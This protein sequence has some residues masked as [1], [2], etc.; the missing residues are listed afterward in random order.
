MHRACFRKQLPGGR[1]KRLFVSY[2]QRFYQGGRKG[3][4]KNPVCFGD[5]FVPEPGQIVP[6]GM[7][8]TGNPDGIDGVHPGIHSFLLQITVVIKKTG[9]VAEEDS[10]EP[11]FKLE[12][13]AQRKGT[14]RF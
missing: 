13:I 6:G 10:G 11:G 7:G 1:R 12:R 5:K 2:A 3:I 8:M 4:F 9:A 14:G